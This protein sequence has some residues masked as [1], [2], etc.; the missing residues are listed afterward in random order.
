MSFF[1]SLGASTNLSTMA[2]RTGKKKN[3]MTEKKRIIDF[4]SNWKGFNLEEFEE[5]M[6]HLVMEKLFI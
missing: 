4:L 3:Q 6:H 1:L 5:I 2:Y